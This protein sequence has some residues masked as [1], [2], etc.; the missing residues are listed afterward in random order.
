V[1][2]YAIPPNNREDEMEYARNP[3]HRA[4]ASIARMVAAGRQLPVSAP[5]NRS[6]LPKI[7]EYH[8]S[9]FHE[10]DSALGDSE[11]PRR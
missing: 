6:V 2:L 10:A 9:L 5:E 8:S 3:V 4:N 11:F 7:S 1:F